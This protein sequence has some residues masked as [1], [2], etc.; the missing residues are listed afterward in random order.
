MKPYL[1]ASLSQFTVPVSIVLLAFLSIDLHGKGV[2]SGQMPAEEARS[3]HNRS[4]LAFSC[5]GDW[6]CNNWGQLCKNL[7]GW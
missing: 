6:D 4:D 5:L 7:F 3:A 1:L 2:E